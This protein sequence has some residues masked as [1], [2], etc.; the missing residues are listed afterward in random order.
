[1]KATLIERLPGN[2]AMY[3]ISYNKP[4]LPGQW[5]AADNRRFAVFKCS[6]HQVQFISP[7]STSVPNT[8]EV[9]GE[10]LVLP[11]EDKPLLLMADEKA[12]PLLFYLI[13]YLRRHWGDKKTVRRIHQVILGAERFF[14][15]KPVPSSFLIPNMPEGVIATSQLLEDLGLPARLACVNYLPG[16]YTGSLPEMLD[17]LNLTTFKVNEISVVAIGSSELLET[18][19]KL[20]DERAIKQFLIEF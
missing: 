6:D 3:Q 5:L 14:P 8:F 11:D 10:P 12:I 17:Q 2:Q 9:T 15:F 19:K 13:H 16:C 20:F 7:E 1:M 18:T 4:V